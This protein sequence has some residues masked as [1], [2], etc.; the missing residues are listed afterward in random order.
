MMPDKKS[1]SFERSGFNYFTPLATRWSDGDPLGHINN[2]MLVRYIESGRID[3]F[4]KVHAVDPNPENGQGYIL[5]N[6]QIAFLRELHYP[7][8]VEIATRVSRLGSSSFD[9]EGAIFV[10][11]DD[12]PILTS[13]A[14]CV[15]FDFK[16]KKS[17]PIP[18]SLR[19]TI[20]NYDKEVQQ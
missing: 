15:W 12:R 17:N 4:L 19:Q 16:Q 10:P 20:I 6:Y 18:E 3:Y 5:A 14:V 9:V 8:E 2:A 13:T 7:A 1:A 11:A